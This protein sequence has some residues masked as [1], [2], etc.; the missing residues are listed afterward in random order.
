VCRKGVDDSQLLYL[1][2]KPRPKVPKSP[3]KGPHRDG[4]G[5]GDKSDGGAKPRLRPSTKLRAL[6]KEIDGMVSSD[7]ESK[8]IVFSQWT[9]MLDLVEVRG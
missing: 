2:A 6:L 5:A 3:S 8:C 9:T 7:P 1:E 4:G